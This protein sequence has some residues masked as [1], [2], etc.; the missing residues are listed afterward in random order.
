MWKFHGDVEEITKTNIK[1]KGG[2]IF[3]NSDGYVYNTFK[4]YMK[5]HLNHPFIIV[6]V[7]YSELDK[8]IS[9]NIISLL[10]NSHP[11][12]TYRIVVD[13]KFLNKEKY[14]VGPSSFILP[15]IFNTLIQ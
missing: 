8:T 3:P 9:K 10:E 5:N 12:L 11:R 2:W 13:L 14:V 6:I 7:G 4:R 1:G 15:R